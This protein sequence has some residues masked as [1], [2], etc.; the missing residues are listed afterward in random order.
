MQSLFIAPPLSNSWIVVVGRLF[1]HPTQPH[2]NYGYGNVLRPRSVP[3][4]FKVP[5]L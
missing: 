5:I 4:A 2:I 1:T 3:L